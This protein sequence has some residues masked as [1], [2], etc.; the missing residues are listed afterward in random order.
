M[1]EGKEPNERVLF[2]VWKKLDTHPHAEGIA[3]AL[4]PDIDAD[5]GTCQSYEHIGQ[6]GGADLELVLS[7]TRPA[8]QVEYAD[9]KAELG[10]IG[11]DL[12]VIDA[13]ELADTFSGHHE[14]RE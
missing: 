10:E 2:R 8:S 12:C 7:L 11:Y 6:H 13:E 1:K 3:I 4:F 9:L 14:I 5:R